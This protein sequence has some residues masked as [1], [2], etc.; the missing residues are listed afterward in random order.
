ML[1]P[2]P[3][4]NLLA[5]PR[6]VA[7]LAS[8]SSPDRRHGA[9]L[10]LFVA[11]LL[12]ACGQA[13]S[14]RPAPATVV[15]AAAVLDLTGSDLVPGSEPPHSCAVSELTYEAAADVPAAFSFH[16]DQLTKAGWKEETG[17]M[18][19]PAMASAVFTKD[20]FAISL[21]VM[22]GAPGRSMV[23]LTN[24]GNVRPDS[25]PLPEGG[26]PVFASPVVAIFS[27]P[28]SPEA[29]RTGAAAVLL[30]DGWTPYGSAGDVRWFKK[31]AI[32][33]SLNVTAAPA[34]TVISVE[35]LLLP[36]DLPVPPGTSRVD[37]ATSLKR[38]AF[39]TSADPVAVMDFYRTSVPSWTTRMT[40][41]TEEE[42]RQ[43]LAFRNPQNDM[44]TLSLKHTPEGG[45]D[46]SLEFMS[47]AEID[48][49]NRRLDAQAEAHK[50][51]R[52]AA[53]ST[54]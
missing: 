6:V 4:V 27:H 28:S 21:T 44:I 48:K 2:A 53:D 46:A 45:S 35:T 47:A 37:Y 17:S 29:V 19:T 15:E 50:K 8:M 49:M 12:A 11:S 36:A 40:E 25:L 10:G 33:V 43:V 42:G 26:Q 5:L 18:D 24:H 39:T 7:E 51:A 54:R 22:P 52:E 16:R 38:V 32:R 41:P 20:G 9:A 31:N 30:E 34:G 3:A 23:V 1:R 13:G 14:S